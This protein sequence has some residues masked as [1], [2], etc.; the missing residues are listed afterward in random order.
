VFPARDADRDL[1]VSY[2]VRM[3]ASL[4]HDNPLPD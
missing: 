3:C 4:R 2:G 1:T